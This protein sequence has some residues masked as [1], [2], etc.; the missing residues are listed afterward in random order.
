MALT[1]EEKERVI[2]LN[3]ATYLN[4][5]ICFFLTEKYDKSIEKATKSIELKKTIKAFYRRGKAYAAK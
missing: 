3:A 4:M 2:A 1:E 5:S